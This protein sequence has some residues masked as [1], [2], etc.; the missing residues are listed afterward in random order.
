MI[1]LLLWPLMWLYDLIDQAIAITRVERCVSV[2]RRD[3]AALYRC[4]V[5]MLDAHEPGEA[6][7]ILREEAERARAEQ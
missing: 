7:A 1:Y 6:Y 2:L 3:K 5:R 4:S